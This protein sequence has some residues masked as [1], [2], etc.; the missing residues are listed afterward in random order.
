MLG[1]GMRSVFNEIRNI[2]IFKIRYRWIRVGKGAHCQWTTRFWSPRRHIVLGDDVGIGHGCL[3]QA[4]TEIGNKVMIACNVAFLN[5]D[6]HRYDAVGTAMWDSGRG[7]K[8]K[9]IVEDDVWIG[10]GAILLSP[11]RVGRGA[12]VAAGSVVV[13]EVPRYAIVGG[14]PAKVIKMRFTSEQIEEHER[15]LYPIAA[16]SPAMTN[17]SI[18]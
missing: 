4:D 8:F 1:R 16:K 18:E 13:K 10:H 5:S 17:H 12:I 2:L 9:I 11:M 3:F 14:N 7:D 6:D 15:V